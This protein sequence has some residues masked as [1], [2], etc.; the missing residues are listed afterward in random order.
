MF[1]GG[2]AIEPMLR[3]NAAL[4]FAHG[5]AIRNWLHNRGWFMTLTYKIVGDRSSGID[6]PDHLAPRG[7][8]PASRPPRP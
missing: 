6:L 7:V 4:G 3:Q 1:R 8:S 2:A 5:L